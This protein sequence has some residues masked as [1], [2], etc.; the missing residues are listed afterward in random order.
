MGG[1]VVPWE[2][3]AGR[4]HGLSFLGALLPS[5][6]WTDACKGVKKQME[7]AFGVHFVSQI[8]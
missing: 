6:L 8:L 3:V 7:K 4:E 2:W 1:E 5:P